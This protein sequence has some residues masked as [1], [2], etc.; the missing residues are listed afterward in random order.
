MTPGEFA[1]CI[2]ESLALLYAAKLDELERLTGRTLRVLHIVGGGS[3]NALLNQCAADATGR[4]VLA[5][6]VEATAVGNVLTQ[7]L[8]LGSLPD[9]A[10]ARAVVRRSFT[11]DRYSPQEPQCWEKARAFFS[12]LPS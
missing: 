11:L 6:P 1:R 7:A 8:A 2:F 12:A 3:K 4:E 5:G 9:L 10:A